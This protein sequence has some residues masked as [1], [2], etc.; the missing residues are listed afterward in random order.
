MHSFFNT[1][2]E[3][4]T[5]FIDFFSV[6]L[7]EFDSKLDVLSKGKSK[8][9]RFDGIYSYLY[10]NFF[11]Y[12]IRSLILELHNYKN[13]NLLLGKTAKERFVSFEKI[14]K[15][16]TFIMR[17]HEKYP[18]LKS[19]FEQIITQTAAY[20]Y[21][22]INN[23][24]KDKAEIER[25]FQLKLGE[26]I[27]IH[28]G[29][30]DTH[31][32]GKSVAIIEFD[33]EKIV[34]KPHSLSS[35]IVFKNIINWINSNDVLKCKLNSL[36]SIDCDNYGWQEFIS[37]AECKENIEVENYYYRSGCY[38][39]IFYTLGTN[40]IHYEN[41]IVNGEHPYFI[42]L[43]TL[44]GIYKPGM[45]DSVLTTGFI[46]NKSLSNFFDVDLSGLCGNMQ[47]S[48]KLTTISIVNP[49]TDEM[50]IE[51]QAA[52]I[53]SNNNIVTLNGKDMTVE[54]YTINFINGFKDTI[55]LIIY[56]KDSY[57]K[58][59]EKQFN[60]F[61]KFRQLIR[62]TRVYGEFLIAA[63]Y[64]N[65]L[66]SEDKHIELFQ[67]L[68]NNV[69]DELEHKRISHEI[70]TLLKWEVPYYYCY[71]DSKDLL[72]NNTL[73]H[74]DYFQTTI[75]QSLYNRLKN[76]NSNVKNFQIDIIKKS[77][78][79]VYKNQLM[80]KEFNKVKLSDI[81][82]KLDEKIILQ[83][84]DSISSNAL[85]LKENDDIAFL[86]N[87]IKNERVLLSPINF[88]FYEGGGII[89]LF[90]CL[91][92]LFNDKYYEN[93]SI[94]LLDS[95]ILTYEYYDMKQINTSKI[96]AFFGIGSLMY[97]YYNMAILYNNNDYYL[98]FADI[99]K[100]IFE[101]DCDYL[102]TSTS[103]LDY[104]FLSGISGILVLVVKIY[105]NEKNDLIKKI[106]DKYSNYLLQYISNN[107]L[108][109]I[110]LAHGL[111][112]YS[113]ALIMIY[114]V[115][116][117]SM[118]LDLAK[119]L[120]NKENSIYSKGENI[121]E[122]NTSW[123][124]G[125]TGMLL[126]RNEMLKIEYNN[127]ILDDIIKYLQIVVK[128]GFY[129]MNSMCLSQ[130]IYGNIEVVNQIISSIEE[131]NKIITH[132]EVKKLESKLVNNLSDIQ[133]GLKNNFILDTF[134]NGS[135]GIAY[136]KLRLLYPQLPSILSLDICGT[137][138]HV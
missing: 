116:K 57:I 75:K 82:K 26:I 65:Y 35:H 118:Y 15:N 95:S 91:G 122:I 13:E 63:S 138:R 48:S 37:Y 90:A 108:N 41:V 94:K 42:D 56:N 89:W 66:K 127:K 135:S 101:Y 19:F 114:N 38:L 6:Y 93:I 132:D 85:D 128:K 117:D 50:I 58:L 74:K 123:C 51:N 9:I 126:V 44:V 29:K 83:I 43:E 23:F 88:N 54:D 32:D 131:T 67:K 33:S 16:E 40:D 39:A 76:L 27:D 111:S 46:P 17:F 84:A 73:V 8:K 20:V 24:E 36:K 21:E 72:S 52:K 68:Y 34:Y 103:S 102:K 115:K 12:S 119:E 59:I 137:P 22:I 1:K 5:M 10:E 28:I 87:I 96:S 86:I 30:G 62:H 3:E 92:K 69:K 77:L 31:N 97:L 125:E 80:N 60:I 100:N 71:Y 130:G 136:A 47:I 79:T 11:S 18:V 113:L 45:L 53:S 105:L 49:S 2:T 134:M 121:D 133:L 99:A 98:K 25:R 14:I 112:G 106:I 104:D 4:N 129:N 109:K 61:H 124:T 81:N 78:F 64:P 107:N 110:G 120:I 70:S 7:N 55:E